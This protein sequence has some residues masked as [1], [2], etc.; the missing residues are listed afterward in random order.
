[1][2]DIQASHGYEETSDTLIKHGADV[3]IV[4]DN[5]G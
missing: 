5:G 1:M 4:D 2:H 3:T